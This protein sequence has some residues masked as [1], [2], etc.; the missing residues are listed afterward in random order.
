MGLLGAFAQY[1][2]RTHENDDHDSQDGEFH[3]GVAENIF[4]CLRKL[5]QFGGHHQ[6]PPD[7][8]NQRNDKKGLGKQAMLSK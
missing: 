4:A 2:K 8:R 1:D 6:D 3:D 5:G 7:D